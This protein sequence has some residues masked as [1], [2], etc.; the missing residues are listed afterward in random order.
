M[1]VKRTKAV[2]RLIE[3]AIQAQ[4]RAYCPYSRYPVGAAVL[5]EA[6]RVFAGCN[7]ENASY[8][9]SMCAE[10]VATYHAIAGGQDALSAVCVV[11]AAAK[12]CGACRQVLIEFSDK[13]TEI[14]LVDLNPSTG[15]RKVVKTTVFKL[16]P[17]AFDPLASG[18]LPKNPRNLLK[19]KPSRG[20]R[21]RTGVSRRKR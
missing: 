2:E 10:R 9:L 8:G 13:D 17:M 19:R 1:S 16:L 5:T 6:G 20:R 3:A 12:P 11:G 18:L 14:Y 15:R 4:K 7:V 21:R